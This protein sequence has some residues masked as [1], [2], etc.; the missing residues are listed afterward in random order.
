[1]HQEEST[2]YKP[3][4][5]RPV[6]RWYGDI[7]CL[8][9]V[10]LA[11]Q[12]KAIAGLRFDE[13]R[14][15]GFHF[16]DLDFSHRA[17]LAGLRL[18]VCPRLRLMHDSAGNYNAAWQGYAEVFCDQYQLPMTRLPPT[19]ALTFSHEG[20]LRGFL[21]AYFAWQDVWRSYPKEELLPRQSQPKKVLLHVGCG[22]AGRSPLGPGFKADVWREIRLDAD[23]LVKPDVIGTIT[24]LSAVPT[25]SVDAVFSSHTLEHLYWHE[26]PLALAEIRRVLKPN[27]FTLAWVPDLQAAARWI[28][29]D[30]PFEV[31]MGS[32]NDAVTPFDIVYSHRALVGRDKPHMAH[33]CG[34]TMSTLVGVHQQA[35]FRSVIARPRIV[36]FDLQVLAIPTNVPEGVLK[37]LAA[38]HFQ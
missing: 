18:G 19:N 28:A 12:R 8:D 17:H 34:F 32:A 16:Y 11:A 14:Y 13:E 3:N 25:Q 24:D 35:G 22:Y 15:D 29:E 4:Q 5:T 2:S 38:L 20:D 7:Q 1:M 30:R 33:H 37:A 9:G 10:F 36:G 21:A 26:V 31:L 23:P 6:P 27:G